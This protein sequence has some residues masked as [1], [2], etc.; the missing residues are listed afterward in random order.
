MPMTVLK[1]EWPILRTAFGLKDHFNILMD[2]SIHDRLVENLKSVGGKVL[3]YCSHMKIAES[4]MRE[5]QTNEGTKATL[6]CLIEV[7]SHIF[8]EDVKLLL[9]PVDVS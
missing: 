7:I 1:S 2:F 8:K 5:M 4:N 3:A 9:V 6:I